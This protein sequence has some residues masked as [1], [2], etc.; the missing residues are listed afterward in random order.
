MPTF[1]LFFYFWDKKHIMKW[2]RISLA[3]RLMITNSM[4]S[5]LSGMYNIN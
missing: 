2:M 5:R 3:I 4:K 1:L